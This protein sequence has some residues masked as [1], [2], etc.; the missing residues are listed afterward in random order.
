[1]KA[2][3]HSIGTRGPFILS[4]AAILLL[5]TAM[6]TGWERG[7]RDEGAVAHTWQL[8]MVLQFPLVAA[9]LATANWRRPREIAKVSALQAV[10]FGLALAP[11]ALLKL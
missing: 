10:A 4:A 3:I 7:L 9:F 5:L 8:L 6:T 11:V 1:M 2:F